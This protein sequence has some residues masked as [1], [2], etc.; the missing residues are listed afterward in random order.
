MPRRSSVQVL[1]RVKFGLFFAYLRQRP[2]HVE[3]TS[4]RPITE[5]K[6]INE[7]PVWN[8][9]SFKPR[10][11]DTVPHPEREAD[12]KLQCF[13]SLMIA[14]C[15]TTSSDGWGIV[16]VASYVKEIQPTHCYVLWQY[17]GA[18]WS[19]RGI[20]CPPGLN[21]VNWSAKKCPPFTDASESPADLGPVLSG[22]RKLWNRRSPELRAESA[23][24]PAVFRVK[25]TGTKLKKG[26]KWPLSYFFC[27]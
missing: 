23:P 25:G 17:G 21:R 18:S 16:W 19:V 5:V 22:K 13:W 11:W 24:P 8:S 10:W 26:M 15:S 3:Y 12:Q 1:S 2:Y 4:S 27:I 20:I 6:Q 7:F 14:H 9:K